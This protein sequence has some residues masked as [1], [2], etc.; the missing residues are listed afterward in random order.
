MRKEIYI[1]STD[2]EHNLHVVIWE[3][4]REINSILQISHGMIEYVA[5]YA[6]VAEYLCS[7]GVLVIGN[8]HLGHGLSVKD[9]SEFGYIAKGLSK[10]LVDDLYEVTKFGKKE[11]GSEIP[12]FIMGHS[13]GSFLARRYLMEHGKEVAGAI[14]MGTGRQ[15]PI[16]V[17]ASLVLLK[18]FTATKG[19]RYHSKFM[20][21]LAHGSYNKKIKNPKTP[22]DWLST[23]EAKVMEY[24]NDPLCQF[25]FTVNGYATLIDTFRFIQKKKNIEMIPKDLP[26]FFISGS[27]DPVGEYGKGFQAVYNSYEKA[28]IKNMQKHLIEGNRHEPLNDVN[29]EEVY[30]EIRSFIQK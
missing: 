1:P 16:L 18:L 23:D 22:S 11:Y 10:T 21:K 20:V 3:P 19:D 6:G 9:E 15:A 29:R 14:I 24:V 5:R 4:E 17:T 8:D 28:G 13:M 2:G 26:L 12:Y 25:T 27:E 30:E 7:R